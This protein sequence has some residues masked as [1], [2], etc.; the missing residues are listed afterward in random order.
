LKHWRDTR[1]LLEISAS[2]LTAV[3]LESAGDH[4]SVLALALASYGSSNLGIF[5]DASFE[6]GTGVAARACTR[7]VYAL[8]A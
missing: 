7:L 1:Q 6:L 4:A 5:A 8:P 3:A 2:S